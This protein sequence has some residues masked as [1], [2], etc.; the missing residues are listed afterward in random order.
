MSD[1]AKWIGKTPE[2]YPEESFAP[3]YYCARLVY[4]PE[5]WLKPEWFERFPYCKGYFWICFQEVY[6]VYTLNIWQN[7]PQTDDTSRGPWTVNWD[8]TKTKGM[9]CFVSKGPDH[10]EPVYTQ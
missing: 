2:S 4:E 8:S 7:E 10:F 5:R 6:R 3:E 9:T 1:Q